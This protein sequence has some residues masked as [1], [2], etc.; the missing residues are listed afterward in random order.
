MRSKSTNGG[1]FY[2]DHG[3]VLLCKPA[4]Q[5]CVQGLTESAQAGQ[6]Q[7]E[8]ALFPLRNP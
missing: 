5:L 4:D 2:S 3:A 7:W 8:E 6:N 1:F